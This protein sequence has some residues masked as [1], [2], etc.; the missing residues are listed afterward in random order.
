MT[1]ANQQPL[2]LR[3]VLDLFKAIRQDDPEFP[4]QQI[5][6]LLFIASKGETS[7]QEV[8]EAVGFG[9]SAASRIVWVLYNRHGFVKIAEDG[10]DRRIK[11][12]SLTEKGKR[13][14]HRVLTSTNPSL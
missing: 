1:M 12:V 7:V 5:H 9:R 8:G 3:D 13:F 6:A 2:S 14:V 4:S 10:L 11:R